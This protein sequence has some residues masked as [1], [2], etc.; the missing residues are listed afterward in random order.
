MTS[1]ENC[2]QFVL[3]FFYYLHHVGGVRFHADTLRKKMSDLLQPSTNPIILLI[4][5]DRYLTQVRFVRTA[6]E[7]LSINEE[8]ITTINLN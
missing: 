5:L 2:F 6:R 8:A 4:P 1:W 7:I 3:S